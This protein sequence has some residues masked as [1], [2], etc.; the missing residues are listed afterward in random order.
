V[1]INIMFLEDKSGCCYLLLVVVLV[2]DV[3]VRGLC[4]SSGM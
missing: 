1:I 2:L 4:V 3:Y